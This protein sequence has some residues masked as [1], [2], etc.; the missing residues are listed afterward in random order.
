MTGPGRNAAI[1]VL[2]M[3]LVFACS[4]IPF[5]GSEEEEPEFPTASGRLVQKTGAS[6][7]V[8]VALVELET[9]VEVR[10]T[11]QAGRPISGVHVLT[12]TDGESLHVLVADSLG[13]YEPAVEWVE[14]GTTGGA[15]PSGLQP[16]VE[17]LTIALT[18]L[19]VAQVVQIATNVVEIL[20][21]PPPVGRLRGDF[22]Y[23][24]HCRVLS[25]RQLSNEIDAFLS[26]G[27]LFASQIIAVE[28]VLQQVTLELLM[29]AG[30]NAG[31]TVLERYLGQ[32]RQYEF[33]TYLS[34]GIG[35]HRFASIREVDVRIAVTE[36]GFDNVGAILDELGYD[37]DT[38]SA[39]QL[40]LSGVVNSYDLLFINCD[41]ILDSTVAA[42]EPVLRS[43]VNG[44]GGLYSSDF[45]AHYL[46]AL[47]P[48]QIFF[49]SPMNIGTVQT[50]PGQIVDPALARFVGR[51]TMSI[52]FDLTGWIPMDA[53]APGARVYIT[54]TYQTSSSSI[55]GS[56]THIEADEAPAGLVPSAAASGPLAVG[57]QLGNGYVIHTAFHHHVQQSFFERNVLAFLISKL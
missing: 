50:V 53:V 45:A 9:P 40:G 30:E 57:F 31:G 56:A 14:I 46:R 7:T 41:E 20:Q 6:G 24:E 37:Y 38:I 26:I 11:D 5:V 42:A 54:G 3:L 4:E 51:S 49:P 1:V 19:T 35:F 44:G 13:R 15:T 52:A 12:S 16:A 34:P 21:D 29:Q 43:F 8:G 17:P 22:G 32:T 39:S 23:F 47:A 25:G 27:L 36:P 55:S 2:C 28:T 10:V 48:E 33:C 18:L